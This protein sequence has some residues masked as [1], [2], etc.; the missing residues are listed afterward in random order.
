MW[1]NSDPTVAVKKDPLLLFQTAEL[2]AMMPYRLGLYLDRILAAVVACTHL[3]DELM[4]LFGGHAPGFDPAHLA[5]VNPMMTFCLIYS[6]D[7]VFGI[8][9]ALA[10]TQVEQISIIEAVAKRPLMVDQGLYQIVNSFELLEG[11]YA[12]GMNHHLHHS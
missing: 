6:H 12:I 11:E 8:V 2:A 10:I 7:G 1:Q 5:T 4:N 3:L 9:L